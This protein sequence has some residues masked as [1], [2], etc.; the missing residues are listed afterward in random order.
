[1]MLL[2]AV[3]VV[4]LIACSHAASLWLARASARS[5][6]ISLR[7][8]LGAGRAR[9]VRQLLVESV[10][11]AFL[12][13]ILGVAVAWTL[14][15]A[16]ANEVAGFGMPYWTRFTFDAPLSV[17]IAL[18]C[19][20]TGI[21]FG[22]LPAWHQSRTDLS[23]V[24]NQGGRSGTAGPRARRTTKWL[25]AA[26]MALTLVLLA[27]A[28][29]LAR[30]AAVVYRADQVID[31]ANLWEYRIALP[32]AKYDTA[33]AR[34]RFY[35]EL[36]RRLAASG[37]VESAALASAPPF[38]ARE[39]RGVAIDRAPGDASSLPSARLVAIGPRYF[40][41]LGLKIL[42]GSALDDA[43]R[44]RQGPAA[45]VNEQFARRF[46]AD[47]DP[48][49]RDLWLVNERSSSAPERYTIV[50]IAPPLRQQIAAGHTPV[51][52]VPHATEPGSIASIII[53]GRADR[54]AA[55]V[56][57]QVRQL[58]PDLPLFNLQSLER[59]SY[60]SR[61]IQRIMSTAFA[62]VAVMATML[63]ALGLYSLTAYAASQRTREVGVRM[64]L[65]AREAQVSWLFLRDAMQFTGVGLVIGLGGAV[66]VGTVL[67]SAL[68]DVQANHPLWLLAVCGFLT[69]VALAAALLP[70]RRAARV[71]PITTLRH[72]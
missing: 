48:I 23:E 25:L 29:A 21:A 24:L 60:N 68:V 43:D 49:G 41:T 4:L 26:E 57:Q 59:V 38:A 16:F 53:R 55:A 13:G 15:R 7:A 28:T 22:T 11:S 32:P 17:V 9:L 56:R 5:R 18:V 37:D 6:E 46:S 20:A 1:M 3:A 44:S 33:D 42:R 45:L 8:A 62:I 61:W 66:A 65:G 10:V 72:D 19:L 52:Y 2:A 50:G 35:D 71:D 69:G 31:V 36:E 51:V 64:A 70:A 58:D 63:S 34:R 27:S 30:S 14:V 47:A 12:A 67:Q 40:Q 39:S 54:F